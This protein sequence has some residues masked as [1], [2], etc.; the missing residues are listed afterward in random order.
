MSFTYSGSLDVQRGVCFVF[1]TDAYVFKPTAECRIGI[2]GHPL[3]YVSAGEEFL[4]KQGAKYVFD[5]DTTVMIGY[6]PEQ[7]VLEAT[8]KSPTQF[9][10]SEDFDSTVPVNETVDLLAVACPVA[11]NGATATANFSINNFKQGNISGKITQNGTQID[12]G[13]ISYSAN[14]PRGILTL[15]ASGLSVSEGDQFKLV[16]ITSNLDGGVELPIIGSATIQISGIP[17]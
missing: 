2:D 9:N 17:S 15:S 16:M 8:L 7:P 13:T 3:I 14:G 5:R 10:A 6:K 4:T 11:M 1:P 12:Y